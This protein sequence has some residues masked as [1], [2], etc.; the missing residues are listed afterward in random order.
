[1]P[2][3]RDAPLQAAGAHGE[4]NAEREITLYRWVH[5]EEDR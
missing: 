2:I 4:V 5:P 1:M 3:L